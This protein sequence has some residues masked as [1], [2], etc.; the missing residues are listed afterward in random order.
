MH[1]INNLIHQTKNANGKFKK[2][3]YSI[4]SKKA[5]KV[6]DIAQDGPHQ[7]SLIIWDGWAGENQ[8]FTIIQDGPDY[9]IRCRKDGGFL[10]VES[11][12]DGA[13]LFTA[14]QPG[15]TS[16]FRFDE[17]KPKSKE[18]IIYTF[19]GKTIDLWQGDK[20]NGTQ[21]IQWTF[22]GNSNQIWY[23]NDPKN[24]T[25]SSSGKD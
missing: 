1:A 4:V 9:L 2:P 6:L 25:S 22:N 19:C 8:S 5:G 17:T 15:P 3:F 16:R 13:R 12:A 10:T 14:P 21:V 20:H 11:D 18:Y 24:L 23:A 7:G